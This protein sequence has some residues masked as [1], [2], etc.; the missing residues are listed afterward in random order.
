MSEITARIR[1]A[2]YWEVA[3]HPTSFQEKRIPNVLDVLPTVQKCVVE[4]RG[5]DFPHIDRNVNPVVRLDFVEQESEWEQFAERWRL[6]QSGQ[7][8]LLR[9]MHHDWRDRSGLWPPD[10]KWKRGATLGIGDALYTLFEVFEFAARLSNTVAGDDRMSIS[11]TV[12]GL[13]G[14]MLVVDDP[15]RFGVPRPEHVAGIDAFPMEYQRSRTEL[16]ANPAELAIG[17]ARE[18]FARFNWDIP[19]ER[20]TEWLGTLLLR[21]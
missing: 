6:Y 15:R 14:R 1:T 19:I 17:A 3:I 12:G 20:L 2:G 9:A 16:L 5:W 13:R 4:I 11:I 10:A 21:G 8:V 7:F 18:L